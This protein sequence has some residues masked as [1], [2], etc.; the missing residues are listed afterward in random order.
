MTARAVSLSLAGMGSIGLLFVPAMRGGELTSVAH[1]LLTPLL[2]SI[3]GCFVH[4]LG[5]RPANGLGRRLLSGW[6]LWPSTC[7]LGLGFALAL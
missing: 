1:G 2:L 6:L 3:C 7:S 5:Y 4:G